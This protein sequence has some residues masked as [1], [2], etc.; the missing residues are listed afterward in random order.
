M[1]FLKK[2]RAFDIV[3]ILVLIAAVMIGILTFLG[4]RATS[5]AQIEASV[6]VEIEAFFRG[7][8]VTSANSPFKEGD[9]TFIT[10]R[11]VP[12][13]KLKIK[14][15]AFERKKTV[16]PTINPKQ[17]FAVVDDVS[18]PFQYDYLVTV[19]D[20]AK[21]TKDGAVVGGNKIKIGLPVIFE[22]P[23]YKLP[24]VVTNIT[25]VSQPSKESNSDISKQVQENQ[26]VH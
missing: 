4:K 19:L 16:V 23:D 11:N 10:I 24:G 20:D 12:Y 18:S 5:S 21:I 15:V 1:E 9:E 17:P 8:L 26:D 22:G 25:I 6:P 14:R 13:T 2:L 3:I 7:V